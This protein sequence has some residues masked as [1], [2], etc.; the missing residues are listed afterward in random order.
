MRTNYPTRPRS[1]TAADGHA[2][3]RTVRTVLKFALVT[4]L[5]LVTALVVVG[6]LASAGSLTS[7]VTA[8]GLLAA[9]VVVGAL[10]DRAR[11]DLPDRDGTRQPPYGPRLRR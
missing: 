7:V 8:F 10:V 3:R 9:P 1:R 2:R 4:P 5:A 6:A 11:A